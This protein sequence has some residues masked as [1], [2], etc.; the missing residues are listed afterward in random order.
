[1]KHFRI[2]LGVLAIVFG[3]TALQAQNSPQADKLIK[4]SKS[5][6]E[7]L[8]DLQAANKRLDVQK[9]EDIPGLDFINRL[10]PDSF[11]PYSSRNIS[12]SSGSSSSAICASILADTMII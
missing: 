10:R 12:F 9:K 6:Y 4:Q 3:V 1:M 7:G 8:K 2:A 5:K 11:N